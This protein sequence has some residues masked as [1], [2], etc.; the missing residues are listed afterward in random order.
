M[1]GHVVL[2]EWLSGSY[3]RLDAPTREQALTVDLEIHSPKLGAL[4]TEG[5]WRLTGAIDA[6]GLATRRQLHGSLTFR[7]VDERRVPYRFSFAGD[8]ERRYELS[9]QKEWIGFSPLESL[10]T[11]AAS[12]YD[13]GGEET[14]RTTL[15]FDWRADW[16]R[17]IRS[18]RLRL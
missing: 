8:D 1:R 9:G 3:W 12:I 4:V 18:I 15:R 11:L 6:E 10:T 5:T 7:L 2:R 13:D 14:A 16:A 17:W